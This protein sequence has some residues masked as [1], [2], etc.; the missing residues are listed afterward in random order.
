MVC[1][2]FVR[3]PFWRLDEQAQA[4]PVRA[5]GF[6]VD[7]L[8]E[9]PP[10]IGLGAAVFA[11]RT[12]LEA[13]MAESV[14]ARTSAQTRTRFATAYEIRP[15]SY[16]QALRRDLVVAAAQLE[17]VIEA[18]DNAQVD[19]LL[20]MAADWLAQ[21]ITDLAVAEVSENHTSEFF[22]TQTDVL[23]LIAGGAALMGCRNTTS[24]AKTGDLPVS[25]GHRHSLLLCEGGAETPPPLRIACVLIERVLDGLQSLDERGAHGL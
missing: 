4:W 5:S 7:Q 19:L 23:A 24:S 11:N 17:Y 6:P 10:S 20:G 3:A 8:V 22:H 13:V 25:K 18:N 16:D 2:F 12:R 15:R 21:T 14:T 1:G 9:L